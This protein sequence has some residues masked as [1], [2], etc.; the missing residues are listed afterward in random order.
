LP[1][2]VEFSVKMSAQPNITQFFNSRKRAASSS[3]PSRSKLLIL[4]AQDA[5]KKKQQVPV[6]VTPLQPPPEA[7]QLEAK[8]AQDAPK[9]CKVVRSLDFNDLKKKVAAN[10]TA[11]EKLKKSLDKFQKLDAKLKIKPFEGALE[12]EL[13]ER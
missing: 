1:L 5:A 3:A 9:K 13:P 11:R 6:E 7:T 2:I 12:I 8:A 10:A 4:E